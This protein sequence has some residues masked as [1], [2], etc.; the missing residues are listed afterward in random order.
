M[1]KK[2]LFNLNIFSIVIGFVG[3]LFYSAVRKKTVKEIRSGEG[4]LNI[5]TRVEE[6]SLDFLRSKKLQ[7]ENQVKCFNFLNIDTST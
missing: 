1:V 3:W 5:Q 7:N 2:N 6:T 4:Q